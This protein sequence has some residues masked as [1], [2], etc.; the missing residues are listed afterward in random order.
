MKNTINHIFNIVSRFYGR[1]FC[2]FTSFESINE[3]INLCLSIERIFLKYCD[4]IL[5]TP[6]LL[7]INTTRYGVSTQCIPGRDMVEA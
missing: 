5:Q 2:T 4:N 1:D 7:E 3:I 6:S